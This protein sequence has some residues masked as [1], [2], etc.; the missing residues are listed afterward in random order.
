MKKCLIAGLIIWVFFLAGCGGGQ[1]EEL[2]RLENRMGFGVSYSN[3]WENS[4][5]PGDDYVE[6][7]SM[8]NKEKVRVTV[9]IGFDSK[10]TAWDN[11]VKPYTGSGWSVFLLNRKDIGPERWYEYKVTPVDASSGQPF[12]GFIVV[13]KFAQ[14]WLILNLESFVVIDEELR[15]DFAEIVKNASVK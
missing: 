13:K 14:S 6:L 3:Q 4:P 11:L 1:T 8:K 12:T 9:R 5:V 15:N 2:N 7:V 10:E